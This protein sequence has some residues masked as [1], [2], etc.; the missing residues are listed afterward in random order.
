MPN[1]YAVIMAGGVGS[2]FWPRSREKT[3]KQLLEIIGTGTMIQNTVKRISDIIEPQNIFIVTNKVQQHLL[4]Q[5]L[6]HIPEKNIII[7]PIGRNTAPCIGLAAL[8][9]RR[10]DPDAVMVVLP[11]DHVIQK[12][13]GFRSVL[14]LAIWVAYES[15][16][17]ITV[18]I[19]PTRPETGYGY[20]QVVDEE[21]TSNPY[22]S[23]GVYRVKT[24]AEK[25][26]RQT[27]EEF[28]KSGD[29][30]WNSGMFIWKVD[31]IL[32]NIQTLLPELWAELS[33]IDDA[34]E[35]E[36]YNNIVETSYRIIR[37][38]SIDYG[39]MEKASNVFVIKGDLGWSDVGSWDE[40]F[41]LSDKDENG[42]T[43]TGK[44][45]IHN[46]KNTMVYAGN[47]FVAAIGV[48]NL[49]IIVTD[50]AVLVCR[51]DHAQEVKE[52][53]DY[54]RRKQFHEFL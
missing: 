39:V 26:N 48:E 38:I 7:E 24:F 17:L 51:V 8:F 43:L 18:G 2:R 15:G 23:R 22:F 36:K 1:V 11:A 4:S 29:F 13:E 25:P 53:V 31:A 16:H 46:T 40:V 47:K 44:V 21:D 28:L 32:Q 34:I 5:Q 42:N 52:V 49:H 35:T 41:R 20:I 19:Q 3:P 54:L 14:R 6:P 30:L 45:Y 37:G 10:K 12:E 27:A 33:K 9:I 50:D